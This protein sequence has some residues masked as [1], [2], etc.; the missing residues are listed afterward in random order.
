MSKRCP[1][2]GS[3]ELVDIVGFPG[4][5]RCMSCGE[6]LLERHLLQETVFTQITASPEVLAKSSVYCLSSD[7][8]RTDDGKFT[9]K[10]NWK[11]P[12]IDRCYDTEEEAFTATVAKLKEEVVK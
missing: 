7:L 3:D 9:V 4:E 10:R 1:M 6:E 11:S 2:C 5:F 8:C 12:F